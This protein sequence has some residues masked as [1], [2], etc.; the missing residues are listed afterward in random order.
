VK[1]KRPWQESMTQEIV[2]D[3]QSS[4]GAKGVYATNT[5][6]AARTLGGD[7]LHEHDFLLESLDDEDEEG[8]DSL[9]GEA[10]RKAGMS[11]GRG[12]GRGRGRG[13]RDSGRYGRMR[14]SHAPLQGPTSS[15]S[16]VED[17]KKA[18]KTKPK[19]VVF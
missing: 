9:R 19:T 5:N 11:G 4:Q 1:E 6:A 12:R 7:D 2:F 17:R 3:E 13:A 15:R 8:L 10:V 18:N 16:P 14:N